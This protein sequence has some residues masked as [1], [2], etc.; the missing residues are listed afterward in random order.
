MLRGSR[1][2]GSAP[3]ST[4]AD[5]QDAVVGQDLGALELSVV[6]QIVVV[7]VR[8][9]Q[10]GEVAEG[11]A[12]T[13]RGRRQTGLAVDRRGLGQVLDDRSLE[14]ADEQ[15]AAR[16][17]RARRMGLEWGVG[18][19]LARIDDRVEALV[20]AVAAEDD[21]TDE[22]QLERLGFG[23]GFRGC[24]G[25]AAAGLTRVRACAL[26]EQPRELAVAVAQQQGHTHGRRDA[27]LAD[28]AGEVALAGLLQ[29]GHPLGALL[30]VALDRDVERERFVEHRLTRCLLVS[31]QLAGHA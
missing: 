23:L 11:R 9:R 25:R 2:G 6:A 30:G 29:L 28:A 12:W 22:G 21:V 7:I 14:V 24:G 3:R 5:R 26:V 1:L 20:V 27:G 4:R 8:Q 17:R 13:S 15:V 18:G 10:D 16:C 19:D 31:R